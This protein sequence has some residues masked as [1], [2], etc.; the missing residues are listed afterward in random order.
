MSCLRH[1]N[2]EKEDERSHF[3]EKGLLLYKT[4]FICSIFM[5]LIK[6]VM[7]AA[8]LKRGREEFFLEVISVSD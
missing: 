5:F 3:Y 6:N 4:L 1:D 2:I 7:P 8:W